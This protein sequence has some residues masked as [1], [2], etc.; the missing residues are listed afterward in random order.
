MK[1]QLVQYLFIM[2]LVLPTGPVFADSVD[3][4][5]EWAQQATLSTPVSGRIQAVHVDI[6]ALVSKGDL[7]LELDPGPFRV[8][9]E[10]G[11]ARVA[12]TQAEMDEA[13]REEQRA[14]ELFDRTV[15]STHE[16]QLVEIALAKARAELASAKAALKQARLDLD[17]S[18][19]HA[20]YAGV[21]V[22]RHVA[23]GETVIQT[24]LA[25]PMLKIAGKRSMAASALI[26]AQQASALSPGDKV[27]VRANGQVYSALVRQLG[28]ELQ[29]RGSVSGYRLKVVFDLAD[30]TLL[31]SGL[32]ATIELP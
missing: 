7:L 5:L 24:Q 17:Y 13:K 28:Y 6:G 25:Q 9:V 4:K 18:R 20:P 19:I 16:Q 30:G 27:Q 10:Q 2:M 11:R 23:A 26:N 8:R 12:A 15:M 3:A 21:V 31:R 1:Q 29:S 22:A 32:P 14:K